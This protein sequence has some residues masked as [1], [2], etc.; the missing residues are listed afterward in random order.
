[1]TIERH[2]ID[3]SFMTDI[4]S[5]YDD[6]LKFLNRLI[7]SAPRDPS[8][9]STFGSRGIAVAGYGSVLNVEPSQIVHAIHLGAEAHAALFAAMTARESPV[10][11]KVGDGEPVTYTSPP[12]ESTIH[13][14]RWITGFYLNELVQ[15]QPA[16]TRLCEVTPEAL[17]RSSTT[18]SPYEYLYMDALRAF[19]TGQLGGSV[20]TLLAAVKGTDP[21]LPGIVNA[22]WTLHL[23]VPQLEVLIHLVTE[24]AKFGDALARGVE[25]HKKYWSKGKM[26]KRDYHG[27][28]SVELTALAA[29]G[30]DRGLPFEVE[31]PYLPVSLFRK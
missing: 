4:A 26:R 23:H 30:K 27:Y 13:V 5:G 28:I 21:K 15:N 11:V 17:G 22:D 20:Q 12:D 18:G 2:K 6:D 3:E 31:S 10:T 8:N 1:M 16:V 29:L 9:L 7:S 19:G 25:L 24:D 14:G